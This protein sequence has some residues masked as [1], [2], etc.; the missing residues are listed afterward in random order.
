MGD[1]W[2]SDP[3]Q[4]CHCLPNLTVQCSPYCP[5]AVSGCPQGQDLVPGEGDRCC[6]CQGGNDTITVTI[7]PV[8]VT[9]KPAE[10]TTPLVPTYPLPPGDECWS[11]LGVQTLPASSFRASSQQSGHPPEAGRLHWRDP[12]T[13][14]QGWSPEPEEYKDLPQRRPE[15]HASTTQSPYLQIDLLK[16]YNITSVLTQGGGV[17]GTFVSSFY[18]QFSQDSRRWYTYKELVTDARPRA[19]VFHGNHDDRGVAESRLDRMV[20]AQF[21]R[22]LPHDFQ[23]GIYLRLEIMGCGDSNPWSTTPTPPSLVTLAGGCRKKEFQCKNGRCVPAGP[24]GVVCD[25]VNDCGDGSDELYCGTQP[26]P[27]PISPRSCPAGQFS[28]PPPGG[29]IE[30]KQRCDGIPNCPKGEDETGCHYYENITTQ[31]DRP[32][33]PTPAPLRTPPRPTC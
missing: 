33:T 31:S 4:L 24:L 18:L 22:L 20:S 11:P 26:S 25:G 32:H 8:T 3:C 17:F 16:S 28:C 27:T 29:C 23:N 30:A 14:L 7:S 9:S 2:R 1:R 5:H 6:Y 21:V 19:K 15:G 10:G 13:D 12:H